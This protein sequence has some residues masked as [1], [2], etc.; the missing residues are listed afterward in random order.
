MGRSLIIGKRSGNKAVLT[1]ISGEGFSHFH[2]GLLYIPIAPCS[3]SLGMGKKQ[4]LGEGMSNVGGR[5]GLALP[6]ALPPILQLLPVVKSPS[7]PMA[8][9]AVAVKNAV[10]LV[11]EANGLSGKL[12]SPLLKIHAQTMVK[13]TFSHGIIADL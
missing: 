8:V 5:R 6:T 11:E 3:D 12:C 2:C 7:L 1:M 4:V 13:Q 9:A 10:D